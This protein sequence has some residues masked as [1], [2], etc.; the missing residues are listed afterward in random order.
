MEVELLAMGEGLQNSD[1]EPFGEL[2]R[3]ELS[4]ID[5]W[6]VSSDR[7]ALDLAAGVLVGGHRELIFVPSLVEILI[8]WSSNFSCDCRGIVSKDCRT[9]SKSGK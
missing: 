1:A 2:V 7:A 9:N 6:V 3:G 8:L 4:E 5:D